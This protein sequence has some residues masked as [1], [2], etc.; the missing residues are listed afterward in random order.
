MDDVIYNVLNKVNNNCTSYDKSYIEM[1]HVWNGCN[2]L[3]S[4][5]K[6]RILQR[7]RDDNVHIEWKIGETVYDEFNTLYYRYIDFVE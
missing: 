4:N 1:K 7:K 5:L 3:R 2:Q 6:K